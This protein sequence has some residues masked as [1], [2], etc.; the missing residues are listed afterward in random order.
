MCIV[1]I[2]IDQILYLCILKEHVIVLVCQV[3]FEQTMHGTENVKVQR[4]MNNYRGENRG[5]FIAGKS[6]HNQRIEHLWVDL[7]QNIIKIYTTI[8]LYLEEKHGLDITNNIYLFCLHYV[9]L[10]LINQ[11]LLQWK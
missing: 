11:D 10:P 6:V 8:F 1:V 2:I 5:L 9:F 4:Y 3:V 7:A